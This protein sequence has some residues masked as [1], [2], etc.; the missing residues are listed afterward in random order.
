MH[1]EKERGREREEERKN[2][3]KSMLQWPQLCYYKRPDFV[4]FAHGV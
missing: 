4:G 2:E 3:R 1:E